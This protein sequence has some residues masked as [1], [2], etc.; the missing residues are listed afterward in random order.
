MGSLVPAMVAEFGHLIRRGAVFYGQCLGA[1]VAFEVAAELERIDGV[2]PD[3][4]FV[5]SQIAPQRQT[6][7]THT[8]LYDDQRFRRAVKELGGW[9]AGL[10]DNDELWCLIEPTLRADFRLA[11]TY[12]PTSSLISAPITALVGSDDKLIPPAKAQ[13]WSA[14]TRNGFDLE[15]IV[16]GDHLLSRSSSA[17][18]IEILQRTQYSR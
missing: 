10:E 13:G 11:E 12:S 4:V 6:A 3:R 18:I 7:A 16:P 15:V 5:A 2:L 17:K 14:Y 9:P 1:L 8:S